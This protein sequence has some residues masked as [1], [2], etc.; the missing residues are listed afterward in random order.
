MS[1]GCLYR[2]VRFPLAV[3]LDT[4]P[5][6]NAHLAIPRDLREER[7][8]HCGLPNTRLPAD[9]DELP[10]Q[11]P[12]AVTAASASHMASRLVSYNAKSVLH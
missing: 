3:V 12:P 7:V 2:Q 6:S 4:L 8:E 9:E 10:L 1:Q 11:K 5:A